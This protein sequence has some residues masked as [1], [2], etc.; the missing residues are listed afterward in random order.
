M[1]IDKIKVRENGSIDVSSYGK[2]WSRITLNKKQLFLDELFTFYKKHFNLNEKLRFE[3]W[4]CERPVPEVLAETQMFLHLIKIQPDV[5]RYGSLDLVNHIILHEITHNIIE[6]DASNLNLHNDLFATTLCKIGG[7]D[8]R[9]NEI[10]GQKFGR[11]WG[12]S[13]TAASSN[14]DE[15]DEAAD[16]AYE[17]ACDEADKVG[18]P[19]PAFG[20]SFY[21][22]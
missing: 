10:R 7:Y 8:E 22:K 3:V 6:T 5:V 19:R 17:I 16:E 4:P 20:E 15:A 11:K 18:L 1:S 13:I 12:F 9:I 2:Q 14:E 21:N